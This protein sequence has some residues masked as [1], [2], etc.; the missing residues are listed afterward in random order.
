MRTILLV[1]SP[2]TRGTKLMPREQREERVLEAAATEMGRGGYGAA[3]LATI[4]ARA[5]V[6]K[7]MVLSYFGSKENLFACCVERAGRNLADHIEPV[8]TA[9]DAAAPMAQATLT[10]IFTALA[11][12]PHDWNLL[13]DST[14]P[15][16]VAREAANAA[17]GLIAEQ[18][19]RGVGLLASLDILSDADDLEV[20]TGVWMHSVASVVGWWM[21]HPDRTAEEMSARTGRLLAAVAATPPGR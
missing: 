8:L 11:D 3:S 18:A 16:G 6:S 13:I 19:S 7:A 4:G 15:P 1:S 14:V 17:R 20:L 10:A 12:R 2:A 9:P 21:D 5:G